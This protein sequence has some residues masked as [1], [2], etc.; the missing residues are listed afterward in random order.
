M[1]LWV[2]DGGIVDPGGPDEE[3]FP[4]PDVDK[5][6]KVG[7]SLLTDSSRS[8]EVRSKNLQGPLAST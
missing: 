3:T 2:I 7:V 1:G 5:W 6:Q 4:Q 8:I